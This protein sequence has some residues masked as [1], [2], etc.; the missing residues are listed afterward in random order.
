MNCRVNFSRY[1]VSQI[2]RAI[3]APC[4]GL[5]N[6]L[7]CFLHLV[8]VGADDRCNLVVGV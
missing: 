3:C 7:R 2:G 8:E 4:L 6:G 1:R 5:F